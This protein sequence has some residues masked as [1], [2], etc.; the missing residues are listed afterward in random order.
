[1]IEEEI[2]TVGQAMNLLSKHNQWRRG[3]LINPANPIQLGIAIDIV[4]SELDNALDY[5]NVNPFMGNK[6]ENNND[7]K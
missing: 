5:L 1:M 3:A 7:I 2:K 4:L 6:E